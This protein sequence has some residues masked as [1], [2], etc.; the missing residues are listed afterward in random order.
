MVIVY[1]MARYQIAEHL[2]PKDN[3]CVGIQREYDALPDNPFL[4][5]FYDKH[6]DRFHLKNR[7]DLGSPLEGYPRPLRS[8]EQEQEK[9]ILSNSDEFDEPLRQIF[10]YYL[11]RTGRNP[12][13]CRL[14]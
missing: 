12:T 11:E 9:T 4:S 6:A 7:R 8:Q 10:N 5:R 2:D 3:W 13:T 1:E 14:G